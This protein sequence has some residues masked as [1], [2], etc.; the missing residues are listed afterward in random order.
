VKSLQS[1]KRSEL[2]VD[3]LLGGGKVR[4]CKTCGVRRLERR[5]LVDL[6]DKHVS[7]PGKQARR[8]LA[9]ASAQLAGFCSAKCRKVG[10]KRTHKL[11]AQLEDAGR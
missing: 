5:Q 3:A 2:Y 11:R 8:A 1:L 9:L 6:L 4:L 10:R 7:A